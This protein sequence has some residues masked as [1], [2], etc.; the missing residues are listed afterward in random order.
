MI[1]T[2]MS[3]YASLAWKKCKILLFLSSLFFFFDHI[4]K[5]KGYKNYKG[6]PFSSLNPLKFKEFCNR[7]RA[8]S[9]ASLRRLQATPPL[10][11]SLL[12]LPLS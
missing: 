11:T 9:A 6:R 8:L 7:G 2:H 12:K 10:Q 4:R 3:H 1:S 5:L